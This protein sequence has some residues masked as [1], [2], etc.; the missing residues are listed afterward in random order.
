MH[1]RKKDRDYPSASREG[2]RTMP[3]KDTSSLS[4]GEWTGRFSTVEASR[5]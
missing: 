2:G 5:P 3:A 4:F 1:P